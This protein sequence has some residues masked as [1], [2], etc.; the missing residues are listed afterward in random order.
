MNV[1]SAFGKPVRLC[2]KR[3]DDWTDINWETRNQCSC[4][5]ML[6]S[7]SASKRKNLFHEQLLLMLLLLVVLICCFTWMT[8]WLRSY[9]CCT[10]IF[11]YLYNQNEN[12]KQKKCFRKWFNENDN[13][14]NSE[15][16]NQWSEI[17]YQLDFSILSGMHKQKTIS[18]CAGTRVRSCEMC[19]CVPHCRCGLS[20]ASDFFQATNLM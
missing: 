11:E 13:K 12:Q 20:F 10:Q 5:W 14:K 6:E 4:E 15:L 3:T 17:E 2:L 8:V 19:E 1:K 7:Y 16:K 9:C 18:Q